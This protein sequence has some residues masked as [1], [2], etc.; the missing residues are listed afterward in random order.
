MRFTPIVALAILA[1]CTDANP[2]CT[3]SAAPSQASTASTI[4]QAPKA[5]YH[6]YPVR[7]D[8]TL[9]P[10]AIEVAP[11]GI[12]VP[13]PVG[14]ES[15][16]ASNLEGFSQ[17]QPLSDKPAIDNGISSTPPLHLGHG[18]A[19][20][21]P[22][23]VTSSGSTSL[24]PSAKPIYSKLTGGPLL[25]P[26]PPGPQHLIPRGLQ[27]V[28]SRPSNGSSGQGISSEIRQCFN[29]LR[30]LQLLTES[31]LYVQK[32]K[33]HSV[34]YGCYFESV[35]TTFYD[36]TYIELMRE[37][38]WEIDKT[39]RTE[40]RRRFRRCIYKTAENHLSHTS[41]E[42]DTYKVFEHEVGKITYY[43]HLIAP[44]SAKDLVAELPQLSAEDIKKLNLTEYIGKFKGIPNSSAATSASANP[45]EKPGSRLTKR[46]WFTDLMKSVFSSEL[47]NAISNLGQDVETKVAKEAHERHGRENHDPFPMS[48]SKR[49][50][51]SNPVYVHGRLSPITRS[52]P[53]DQ[54]DPA[55]DTNKVLLTVE[56][57]DLYLD[58]IRDQK[59]LDFR[60]YYDLR[61]TVVQELN[62]SHRF[63]NL[64]GDMES[65]K[66]MIAEAYRTAR[67]S[68]EANNVHIPRSISID[69]RS[70]SGLNTKSPAPD[71]PEASLN[72]EFL[73]GVEPL[74]V[75]AAGEPITDPLS[76]GPKGVSP[77]DIPPFDP[78][79]FDFNNQTEK[80]K[81]AVMLATAKADV[82]YLLHEMDLKPSECPEMEDVIKGTN[83]PLPHIVLKRHLTF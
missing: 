76:F 12:V 5:G 81:A 82:I 10:V 22:R 26:S 27:P 69:T 74:N 67:K 36:G 44:E 51:Q 33:E 15:R 56:D 63:S 48:D 8:K 38:C 13:R 65:Y 30:P 4:H 28:N 24:T 7:N 60:E 17:T 46:S 47:D 25:V 2:I 57:V 78:N 11:N 80:C 23:P 6:R 16:H 62:L 31:L 40:R 34:R 55:R 20:E 77:R 29:Q 41:T 66:S 59:N 58:F 83:F 14:L 53:V 45:N 37:I 49:E 39:I 70:P 72:T 42:E 64:F 61:K 73:P 50:A 35:N 68:A 71:E 52:N 32:T 19:V 1:F 9:G 75:D 21:R 3:L 18:P 54:V 43:A 79:S